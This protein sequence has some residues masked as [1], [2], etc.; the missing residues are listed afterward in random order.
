[1]IRAI[2]IG[3]LAGVA[4]FVVISFTTSAW[5]EREFIPGCS[6][7]MI[8]SYITDGWEIVPGQPERCYIRRSRIHFG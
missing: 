4:T 3:A 5:Y 8:R 7:A 2:I 1:M 6:A